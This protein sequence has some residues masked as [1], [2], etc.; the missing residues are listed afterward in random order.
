[1]T[2]ADLENYY[3]K[4]IDGY[5]FSDLETLERAPGNADG[6]GACIYPAVLTCMSAI[7]ILGAIDCDKPYRNTT[8]EACKTCGALTDGEPKGSAH[9]KHFWRKYLYKDKPKRDVHYQLRDGLRNGLA[10]TFM[11]KGAVVIY[12][13]ALNSRHHLTMTLDGVL[14]VEV[15]QLT[16]DLRAAYAAFRAGDVER[17]QVRLERF[18]EIQKDWAKFSPPSGLD[19]VS[20]LVH[21]STPKPSTSMSIAST[22]AAATFKSTAQDDEP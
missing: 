21:E 3:R 1:M 17:S 6:Y 19:S 18:N 12:R 2:Q 15:L 22:S 8:S 14:I 13:D 9:F 16:H 20:F 7:E 10:H 11:P 5:L 4:Y